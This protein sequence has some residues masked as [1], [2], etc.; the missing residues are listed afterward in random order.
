[1][2][3]MLMMITFQL[4]Q[5]WCSHVNNYNERKKK[6]GRFKTI[7]VQ[8]Q[9]AI[10]LS[11]QEKSPKKKFKLYLLAL[12][13]VFL[14][15]SF[16]MTYYSEKIL[17]ACIGSWCFNSKDNLIIY[18]LYVFSTIVIVVLAIFAA[19]LFGRKLAGQI[20]K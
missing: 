8:K 10:F 18:S 6:H 5:N 16:F 15:V 3:V 9:N 11:Q 13:G 17:N 19:Y 2:K 14:L 4:K 20:K 1:M 7:N 12:A